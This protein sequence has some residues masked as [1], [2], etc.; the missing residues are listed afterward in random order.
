VRTLFRGSATS[1]SVRCLETVTLL[2]RIGRAGRVS[3]GLAAI[4][5]AFMLSERYEERWCLPELLCL[6]PRKR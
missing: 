2:S 1:L 3:E 5:Q 6:T 4:E